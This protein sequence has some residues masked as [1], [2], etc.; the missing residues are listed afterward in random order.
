MR[1]VFLLW[2]PL[3][4]QERV[5]KARFKGMFLWWGTLAP[6]RGRLENNKKQI[7]SNTALATTADAPH[8][9]LL[10]RHTRVHDFAVPVSLTLLYN[11]MNVLRQ[12][13]FVLILLNLFLIYCASR[14]TF[15]NPLECSTRSA[16]GRQPASLHWKEV[17][18]KEKKA[19]T[20]GSG[21]SL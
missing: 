7:R 1:F 2:S 20:C 15:W 5:P 9:S 10:L 18:K 17:E 16:L 21:F 11:S 8:F 12:V 3:N 4:W 19:E 13:P 14:S 6:F